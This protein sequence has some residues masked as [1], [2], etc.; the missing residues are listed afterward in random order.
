VPIG[1]RAR[2]LVVVASALVA[3]CPVDDRTLTSPPIEWLDIGASGQ[4]DGASGPDMGGAARAG[5][6][7]GGTA[8]NGVGGSR[9]G[10]GCGTTCT[11]LVN[12]GTFDHDTAAWSFD[13][14]IAAK[15]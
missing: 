14:G 10:P 15:W 1:N 6:D 9:P 12:N 13:A 11:T 5:A 8:G 2:A 3:A 7:T 4:D